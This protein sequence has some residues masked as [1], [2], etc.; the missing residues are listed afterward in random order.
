MTLASLPGVWASSA[1]A[2]ESTARA[3]RWLA[4]ARALGPAVAHQEIDGCWQHRIALGRLR[5]LAAI[6]RPD[7]PGGRGHADHVAFLSGRL[8]LAIGLAPEEAEVVA[9]AGRLHDVGAMGAPRAADGAEL[10]PGSHPVV[11]AQLVAPFDVRTLVGPMIRHHHERLDGSGYPDG[12]RGEQIPV[13][14]RIIAVADEYD[15]LVA[16]ATDPTAPDARDAALAQLARQGRR[17]LDGTLIAALYRS[18][19]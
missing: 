12:L 2:T 17:T 11:G 14:A 5:T 18:L 15:Y 13:G 3:Y 10:A 8:A 7:D 1:G 9:L 4:A 6:L 19:P 16:M